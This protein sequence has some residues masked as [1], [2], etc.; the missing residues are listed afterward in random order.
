MP[1]ALRVSLFTCF[2]A[3]LLAIALLLPPQRR[4]PTRTAQISPASEPPRSSSSSTAARS[5]THT[6][7]TVTTTVSPVRTTPALAIAGSSFPNG[8]RSPWPGIA[9]TPCPSRGRARPPS[10]EEAKLGRVELFNASGAR[11]RLQASPL[12]A[13]GPSEPGPALRRGFLVALPVG[14]ALILELGLSKPDQ[15]AI[16]TGALLAGFPAMDAPAR[17]ARPGRRRPRR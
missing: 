4:L 14:L 6:G 16:G 15:G 11:R 12:F 17:R 7:S 9:V 2:A 5:T 8:L 1:L 13:I 10:D 3:I